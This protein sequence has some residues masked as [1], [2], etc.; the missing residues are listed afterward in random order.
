M[1]DQLAAQWLPAYG[2]AVVRAPH[3]DR[4]AAQGTV[5]DACYTNSPICVAARAAMMTG[6]HISATGAY[7]NGTE[8]AASWPTF[9]HH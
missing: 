7:D 8:F 5:F 4:L 3:L 2:H 6:R 9:V 1:A